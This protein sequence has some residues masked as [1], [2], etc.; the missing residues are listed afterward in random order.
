N[1]ESSNFLESIGWSSDKEWNARRYGTL[2]AP[3][4]S[5]E[6]IGFGF[7]NVLNF[8]EEMESSLRAAESRYEDS[9]SVRNKAL[10]GFEQYARA[11]LSRRFNLAD[12]KIVER[13]FA[14]AGE[15]VN[16]AR[17]D[18]PAWLDARHNV[19]KHVESLI[20]Y[21]GGDDTV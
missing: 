9:K 13:Y 5:V 20:A 1:L 8:W 2:E 21:A 3:R 14:L 10:L 16:R 17:E 15:F 4:L 12:Y 18:T 7:A 11:I 19:F 6:A